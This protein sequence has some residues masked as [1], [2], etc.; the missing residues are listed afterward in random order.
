M[1]ETNIL[2]VSLHYAPYSGVGSARMT[3]L[4]E[5]MLKEG[6][7]VTVVCY[8]SSIYKIDEQQ[9][10]I[11]QGVERIAVLKKKNKIGDI[12][13]LKK[14][15]SQLMS[16]KNYKICIVSV[17]PYIS[18]LFIAGLCKKYKI[19]YII[20]YRDHWLF[21]Y[22]TPIFGIKSFLRRIHDYLCLPIEKYVFQSSEKIVFVSDKSKETI[23]RRYGLDEEKCN[24]ICNGFEVIPEKKENKKNECFKIYIAGKFIAYNYRMALDFLSVCKDIESPYKIEIFHIGNKED[25][26]EAY[27]GIYHDLGVMSYK[28]T[29]VELS[30]ADA[31]LINSGISV[32]LGTKV[33]DYIALNKPI[34]Y[35]GVDPSEISDFIRIFENA[36]ICTNQ[37]EMDVCLH[38][39]IEN[40]TD[41]LTVKD[42]K[43]YSREYQ[44]GKYV[45][46]IEKLIR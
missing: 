3:S 12:I 27:Q 6:Y 19:P 9:R 20:D 24:V 29:M 17:G 4:S 7:K 11:P 5:Y 21:E 25:D 42:I 10:E 43:K 18:Y 8:D 32:G 22:S 38:S 40:Y 45:F 31:F 36:Y 37:K 13:E 30:N 14:T 1:K 23:K 16:I 28:D 34:I 2:I 35:I 26:L 41:F 15:I 39:M 33:F 46:L 44:N